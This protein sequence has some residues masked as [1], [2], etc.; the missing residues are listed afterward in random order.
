MLAESDMQLVDFCK[1]GVDKKLTDLLHNGYEDSK[2]V[3]MAVQWIHEN[4]RTPEEE[5]AM[6]KG[7]VA[8]FKEGFGIGLQEASDIYADE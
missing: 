8:G 3:E 4:A 2:I 6:L 7:F 1:S 5:A